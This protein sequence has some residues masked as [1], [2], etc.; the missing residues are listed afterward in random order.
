MAYISCIH[1]YI[2]N[3]YIYIYIQFIYIYIC[4]YIY[5][6]NYKIKY[7]SVRYMTFAGMVGNSA[8]HTGGPGRAAA[9]ARAGQR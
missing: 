6:H 7:T 2:Y 5:T 3:M 8:Q 4:I 9:A 1:I